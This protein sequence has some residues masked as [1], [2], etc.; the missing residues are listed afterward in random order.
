MDITKSE[1]LIAVGD[2]HSRFHDLSIILRKI[3]DFPEHK[4]I[5]LGDYI[6]DYSDNLGDVLDTFMAMERRA[7]FLKGNHEEEF[8]N[9]YSKYG[10][11]RFRRHKILN[12]FGIS[13]YH[14]DWLNSNLVYWYRCQKV[15]F[16][17]AGIDDTKS[18]EEQT[19][20]DLIYS[21]FRGNL[22]HVDN[23]IMFVQ[24]HIAFDSVRKFGNHFFV[25]SSLGGYLSGLVLPEMVVIDSRSNS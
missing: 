3:E 12:H 14:V 24:G 2:I 4:L 18:L 16:S 13:E 1:K 22:D 25:D 11:D 9:F 15:F 21:A 20:Y 6:D 5:F 17:H 8:L 10:T 23:T 19:S 7:I